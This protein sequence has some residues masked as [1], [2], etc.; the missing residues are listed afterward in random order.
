MAKKA[1]G[2]T[3]VRMLRAAKCPGCGAALKAGE[4]IFKVPPGVEPEY[5]KGRAICRS[6]LKD[7]QAKEVNEDG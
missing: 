4:C 5:P 2:V 1:T 6:C 7:S 3:I